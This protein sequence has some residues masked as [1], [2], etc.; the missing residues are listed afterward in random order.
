MVRRTDEYEG[1]IAETVAI[2]GFG[3]GKACLDFLRA[4]TYTSGNV[5]TFG[6]CSGGRNAYIAACRLQFDA[7]IDCWGGRVVMA[8]EDLNAA[9]PVAPIDLTKDLTA[10]PLGLFGNDD[11][12]P[13]P[14][15]VDQHE[16]E[17]KRLGKDYKFGQSTA[18]RRSG[19]SST[20]HW[21]DQGKDETVCAPPSQTRPTS[22]EAQK[23]ANGWFHVDKVFLGYDHPYHAQFEH[24]ISIDFVNE[25][26]NSRLAVEL[27]RES[28]REMVRQLSEVM[29]EADAY[30]NHQGGSQV[31]RR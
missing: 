14:E 11:A 22:R 2:R 20:A 13:N 23:G 25:A 21:A 15:E 18:G 5:G 4:L 9:Y 6:T 3:D 27:S 1:M 7:V 26:S 8:P 16:A 12:A 30:E 24:A 31:G 19:T 17:L 28:A 29:D 10:P